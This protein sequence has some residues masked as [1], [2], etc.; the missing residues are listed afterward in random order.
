MNDNEKY[1]VDE[2]NLVN[3]PT[4]EEIDDD[5]HEELSVEERIINIEKKTNTILVVVVALMVFTLINTILISTKGSFE[6]SSSEEAQSGYSTENFK[7]IKGSDIVT[8]SKNEKIVVMIGRQTCGYCAKYAP[9]L[10]EVQKEFNLTARYIDLTDIIDL[11]SGQVIDND[12]RDAI[13]NISSD[14]NC[15]VVGTDEE[16]KDL[17]CENFMEN[18][19][20]ATPLTLVI[21]NNKLTYAFAGYVDASGLE[22]QLQ[23]AGFS[24]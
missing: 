17:T 23:N 14:K 1:E 18:N 12:S 7:E 22:E 19:F 8:E 6:A 16:G 2:N 24:K 15:K 3:T 4:L 21:E 11:E 9:I 5:E 20:G 13:V 10:E